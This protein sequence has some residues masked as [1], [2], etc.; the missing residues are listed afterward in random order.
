[1]KMAAEEGFVDNSLSFSKIANFDYTEITTPERKNLVST[2]S[3]LNKYLLKIVENLNNLDTATAKLDEAKPTEARYKEQLETLQ[4]RRESG[5][6]YKKQLNKAFF[7][8]FY[9][10]IQEGSW[11]DNSAID[12]EKYYIAANSVA[13][14]SCLPK[15]TY[16]IDVQ[17]LNGVEDYEAIRYNLG[18]KTWMEDIEFFGYQ[19]GTSIP[20][21][22]E[23]TIT[24]IEYYL[25]EPE[26]DKYTVRN[27]RN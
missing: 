13:Y 9:R 27:Y 3:T 17:T 20:Y 5:L 6:E 1:M 11:V 2:N 18:D 19:P 15:I 24:E 22:E 23:V 26:K 7:K 14:N 4:Q 25:D 12:D 21:R 10:Y 16:T 8:T